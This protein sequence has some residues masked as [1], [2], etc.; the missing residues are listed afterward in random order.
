M[1]KSRCQK[2]LRKNYRVRAPTNYYSSSEKF[3]KAY[4]LD[5]FVWK[6]YIKTADC[7]LFTLFLSLSFLCDIKTPD[8]YIASLFL[9]LSF[10][11][12]ESRRLDLKA[13]G[14]KRVGCMGSNWTKTGS[15]RNCKCM[16][17]SYE[18]EQNYYAKFTLRRLQSVLKGAQVWKFSSHGFFLF[19]H[20]KASMGRRL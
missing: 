3:L 13:I 9:S 8:G 7:Y 5:S 16:G 11:C 12:E 17:V 6:S 10:Q 20:H 19:F 4:S 2:K 15:G 18:S 14:G 1:F